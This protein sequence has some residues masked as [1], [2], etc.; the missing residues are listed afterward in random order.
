MSAD[1][2]PLA[3]NGV[4]SISTAVNSIVQA[5]TADSRPPCRS[6]T[7]LAVLSVTNAL[8]SYL[9]DASVGYQSG[10]D[11]VLDVF[12]LGFENVAAVYGQLLTANT[13]DASLH[14]TLV[15]S[16]EQRFSSLLNAALSGHATGLQGVQF[17]GESY[18][19]ASSRVA[20][21][22]N[23]TLSQLNLTIPAAAVTAGTT[24]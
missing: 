24:S 15:S 6:W 21:A 11:S 1:S 5:V 14:C 8:I 7:V 9:T 18:S 3:I 16:M 4:N 12:N 20:A 19:A 13:S 2:S 10:N 22:T 23:V 17:S